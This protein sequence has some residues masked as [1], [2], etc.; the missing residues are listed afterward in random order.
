MRR[1][2][3]AVL[4]CLA[5]ATPLRGSVVSEDHTYP[6]FQIGVTGI[7]ATIETGLAVTV[8]DVEPGSPADGKLVKGDVIL[9]A[10]RRAMKGQDVRVPLGEALGAAEAS[11]GKLNLTIRRGDAKKRV[12]ITIPALGAYSRTWPLKCGKSK[13]IIEQT[14]AFLVSVQND[15]GGYVLGGRPD[16][17]GIGGCLAGLFLLSTGDDGYLPN[18]KRQAHGLAASAEKSPSR[19]TWALGYQGILLGEYYLRTGDKKV[20]AG[21]KSICDQAARTQYAGAW[22]HGDTVGPGYVQSGLM[23]SAGA[24]LLAAMAL[25][26][27]CGVTS[28][29]VAFGRALEFFY[30]MAGHGAVCYGDHRAELYPNTNGRN[31]KIACGLTLLEGGPYKKAAEHLGLVVSDS[32]YFHEFGHTGGG[33]NVIWRGMG[34]SLMPASKRRNFQ[35]QMDRLAWY[36]DLCRLPGG[37]FSMLP[38]PP[39]T[40]RYCGPNWGTGGVALTY[41]APLKTL[42]ITGKAPTKFSV[43]TKGPALDW[44]TKADLAFLGTEHC[45][46]FGRERAQP[47]EIH[48]K[49]R[50]PGMPPVAFS[51]KM[52]RH[53]SPMVRTWAARKLAERADTASVNEIVKAL[54]HPDVRVRRAACDGI[55]GYDN[56]GRPTSAGRQ[57]GKISPAVVST[58]CLPHIVKMLK[59]TDA[60][61]WEIDGALFALGRAE[62]DDIR[63]NMDLIRKFAKHEEWYIREAAFWAIVGLHKTITGPEFEMLADIYAAETAVFAR[64]SYNG[65]FAFLI[66]GDKVKLDP[67]FEAKVIKKLGR[68]LHS[69]PIAMGYGVAG[70]HEAAHRT[71]MIFKSFDSDI[72]KYIVP[73]LTKYLSAWTPDYMHSMWLI[74]GNGWQTGLVKVAE[75][76]GPDAKPLVAALKRCLAEKVDNAQNAKWAAECR[77]KLEAFIADYEKKY[78][79]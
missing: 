59:N 18:V 21:I 10:G 66:G 65:G 69:A 15:D 13:K 57:R 36:Y 61:W 76:L 17:D 74:T 12:T 27:E 32:Y 23:N 70:T 55:S 72:Y 9:A 47:H 20:L 41:T 35:R 40:T 53:Y 43:N 46:G 56:W 8:A 51:A 48:A 25:G 73:D 38:V 2:F 24:P 44:G 19:S 28:S 42:R 16:R 68:T 75:D 4:C 11:D 37:G 71:M 22:G 78:G 14:A 60:A 62:P 52:M 58:R 67:A 45:E 6:R 1:S 26:R 30:R 49:L 39:S 5:A 29:E 79:K 3:L 33:F 63:A 7:H 77:A 64:S 54:Q 34:T 31:A 50:G